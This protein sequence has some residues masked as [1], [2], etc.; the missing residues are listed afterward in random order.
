LTIN[1]GFIPR[2]EDVVMTPKKG[3]IKYEEGLIRSSHG[4][5]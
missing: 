1:S 2:I 3:V 5:S 4:A